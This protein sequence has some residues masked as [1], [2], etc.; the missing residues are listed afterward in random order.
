[1]ERTITIDDKSV[2]FKSTGAVP[3]RYKAQFA[4]DYLSDLLKLTKLDLSNLRESNFDKLDLEVFYNVAWTL[5][6]TA[7]PTIP[8]P[9][10]W[11]DNFETFPIQE[12][13]PEIQELLWSSLQ[14]TKKK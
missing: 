7:N 1:M 8:D 11:L 14:T 12:I 3:L 2:T 5:A 10:S 6:K 13:I 9:L 4:R